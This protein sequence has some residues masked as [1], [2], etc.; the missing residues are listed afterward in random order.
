MKNLKVFFTLIIFVTILG[1]SDYISHPVEKEK[2]LTDARV[3]KMEIELDNVM[4]NGSIPE[5]IIGVFTDD[6]ENWTVAHGVSNIENYEPMSAEN[7]FGV[8]S[9]T[10]IFARTTVLIAVV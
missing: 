9:N 3:P 10:K 6:G 4:V 7:H 1:C 8:G 2:V 5:T